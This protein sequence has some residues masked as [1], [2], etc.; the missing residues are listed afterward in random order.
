MCR[1]RERVLRTQWH[2]RAA[3]A[4]AVTGVARRLLRAPC[5]FQILSLHTTYAEESKMAARACSGARV[6]CVGSRLLSVSL[7]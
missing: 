1:W 4:A 2:V 3:A 6:A 5:K 7:S